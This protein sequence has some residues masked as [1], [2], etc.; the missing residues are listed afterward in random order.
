MLAGEQ[1]EDRRTLS[2]YNILPGAALHL[3]LTL[4]G[5]GRGWPNLKEELGLMNIAKAVAMWDWDGVMPVS[6]RLELSVMY[7][8]NHLDLGQ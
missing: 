2:D 7:P 4:S 3:V 1:L 6:T 8:K 5:G